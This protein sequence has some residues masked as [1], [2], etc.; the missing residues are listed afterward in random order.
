M[1][2]GETA[3]DEPGLGV[4]GVEADLGSLWPGPLEERES[5]CSDDEGR[6][7]TK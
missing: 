3:G 6:W 2:C 1:L 4:W 7:V 5:G